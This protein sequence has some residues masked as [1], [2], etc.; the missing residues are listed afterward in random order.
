M[1][2]FRDHKGYTTQF[3]AVVVA[4]ITVSGDYLLFS[5]LFSDVALWLQN[6]FKPSKLIYKVKQHDT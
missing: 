5:V 6:I 3:T 2:P 4:T 1:D